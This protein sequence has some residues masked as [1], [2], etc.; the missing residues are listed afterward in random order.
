MID[1]LS[2]NDFILNNKSVFPIL[3]RALNF[4]MILSVTSFYFEKHFGSIDF[5]LFFDKIKVIEY[6]LKGTYIIPLSIAVVVYA[7][8]EYS[9]QIIFFLVN[10]FLS[11]KFERK[12]LQ[13]SV[14]SKDVNEMLNK[15]ENVSNAVTPIKL[16]PELLK[17]AYLEIRKNLSLEIIKLETELIKEKN[18]SES[19]FIFWFR[20]LLTSIFYLTASISGYGWILFILT[21]ISMIVLMTISILHYQTLNIIPTALRKFH[22]EAEK[23]L[24]E[25][26]NSAKNK[27]ER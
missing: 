13:S 12:I 24:A 7:I 10:Y 27:N 9:A 26:Y 8:T 1:K 2:W 23:Y 17:R 18:N 11:L 4:V 15:I 3:R 16:T 22:F 19:N 20:I 14:R 21:A 5:S 6:L 25:Q